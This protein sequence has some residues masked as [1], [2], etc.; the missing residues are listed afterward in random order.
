MTCNH[1]NPVAQTWL[2]QCYNCQLER[3]EAAN[4]EFLH[5]GMLPER[6]ND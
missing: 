1:T 4:N 6:K 3:I 5:T 2:E